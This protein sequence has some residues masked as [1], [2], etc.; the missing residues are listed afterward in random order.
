TQGQH[1]PALNTQQQ[2][3]ASPFNQTGAILQNVALT[4]DRVKASPV[5]TDAVVHLEHRTVAHLKL[6]GGMV[7]A[8][9]HAG[10]CGAASARHMPDTGQQ[11]SCQH[12]QGR[13]APVQQLDTPAHDRHWRRWAPARSVN[14]LGWSTSQ[15]VSWADWRQHCRTYAP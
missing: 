9:G 4:A 7:A 14:W 1:L 11:Q 2:G 15:P 8:F 5:K 6:A 12:G 13:A 10:A 3:A